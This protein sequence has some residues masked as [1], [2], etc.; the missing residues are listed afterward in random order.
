METIALTSEKVAQLFQVTENQQWE[1]LILFEPS[2]QFAGFSAQRR[3]P[4]QGGYLPPCLK[5][6]TPDT[7]ALV[8][9]AAYLTDSEIGSRQWQLRV[10]ISKHSRYLYNRFDY[11]FSDPKSPTKDSVLRSRATRQPLD[12]EF[13]EEYALRLQDGSLAVCGLNGAVRGAPELLETVFMSHTR[14]S[15][16][17]SARRLHYRSGRFLFTIVDEVIFR[18]KAIVKGVLRFEIQESTEIMAYLK[19]IQP[20]QLKSTSI[21]HFEFQGYRASKRSI[22]IV[23]F[24]S[25]FAYIFARSL[26]FDYSYLR[27]IL[28]NPFLSVCAV[29]V[30]V[31]TVDI[32]L[33]RA[34]LALLNSLIWMR[35]RLIG[36]ARK[37]D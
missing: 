19:P 6:G 34:I 11:D 25:V 10:D 28:N 16:P 20:S 1:Q 30:L 35:R 3:Y 17:F 21:E 7:F 29:I 36:F 4:E 26:E 15:S 14:T 24:I 2:T 18:T 9:V 5:D 22:V 13:N 32:L 37:K 31:G 23:A 12:L 27:S 33:P 8:R